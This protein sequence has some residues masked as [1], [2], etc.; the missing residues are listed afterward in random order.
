LEQT[1]SDNTSEKTLATTLERAWFLTLLHTGVRCAELLNLR[2]SDVD[3]A[4]RRLVIHE[5]KDR[6]DRVVYLTPA[7]RTALVAY[8]QQRPSVDDDHLW[9]KANGMRLA[10]HNVKY[11]LH[12][13]GEACGVHVTPHRLR[14][15][16]ATRL[17]NAGLPLASAAKLL[18]HRSLNMTQHY[19]R[20]YE[21]TVKEQFIAAME[22]IEGIASSDWPR[23]EES[24]VTSN[25]RL[26]QT[27]DSV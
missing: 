7:L 11:R 12:R 20:L 3:F 10:Q 2:V 5:G 14:H 24:P 6:R 23:L 19:A 27:C 15:T 13:W 4:G 21:H 18:G 9:I 17:V 25:V 22:N 1:V 16:F 26:E 8:L